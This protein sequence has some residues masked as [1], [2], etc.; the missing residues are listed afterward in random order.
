MQ[1]PSHC[2]WPKPQR[3]K[4][5]WK[6]LT[7]LIETTSCLEAEATNC[8]RIFIIVNRNLPSA[9]HLESFSVIEFHLVKSSMSDGFEE[10]LVEPW[11]TLVEGDEHP[12]QPI[13]KLLSPWR[14]TIF[15]FSCECA[16]YLFLKLIYHG[17]GTVVYP[18]LLKFSMVELIGYSPFEFY[19]L[20]KVVVIYKIC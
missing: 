15:C 9:C 5:L 13:G 16:Y 17:A 11:S 4:N 8:V 18:L 20:C 14:K 12:S 7:R 1:S 3:P 10:K 6:E 19:P 2:I